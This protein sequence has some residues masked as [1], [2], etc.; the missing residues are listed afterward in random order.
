M[1][2]PIL[3]IKDSYFFE[4][5]KMMWRSIYEDRSQ[6]PDFWV[7]CDEEYLTWEAKRFIEASDEFNLPGDSGQLLGEYAH[8]LH[9]DHAN[10]GKPFQ[11][12]IESKEWFLEKEA[13]L[14]KNQVA[15]KR[16]KTQPEEAAQAQSR[17]DELNGWFAKWQGVQDQSRDVAAYRDEAPAWSQKKITA[18]NKALDGKILIPQPFGT[19][20][21]L[22]QPESGFCISKFMIIEVIVALLAALLFI[23][24]ANRMRTSDRPKGRVWNFF[25]S[26]LLFMRDE[27]AVPA[28]GKKDA[29]RFMPLLWTIFF[30]I[31]GLNLMGMVPWVGAPTGAFAV[32]LG[33]A[34]VTLLTG[35]IM[36]TIKFGPLGYWKNQ[37]PSMD[38]PLWISIFVKPLIFAIEVLGLFIKHM[39]LGI[40][41]LAN[42][43]A[44]H[45][46]LLGVMGIAFSVQGAMSDSWW[47]AAPV[48]VIGS[49]IFSVLELFVAFLQAYIFTF[50]SALF[51][52]AAV[53]HH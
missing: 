18:Y 29:K 53:H 44:G 26:I 2:S 14:A 24:L 25:E 20:R 23:R 46:V 4:V 11:S 22:H 42:M 41:L 34:A 38:L 49:T 40:R 31:L 35:F 27:V 33:L 1:S 9:A 36:G 17:V 45:L 3:H 19:L 7:A 50:L 15:A 21:N 30:F 28:M 13:E 48:S 12:F 39:V 8:W 32:T 6:F 37:I 5:P 47:I 10:A 52:G 43:V 16:V 51:I